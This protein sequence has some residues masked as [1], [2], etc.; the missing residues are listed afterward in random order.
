MLHGS[1]EDKYPALTIANPDR[2]HLFYCIL[3]SAQDPVRFCH[4]ETD[5][6]VG[7]SLGVGNRINTEFVCISRGPDV[8]YVSIVEIDASTVDPV[9]FVN[10]AKSL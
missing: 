6:L 9:Q 10:F 1:L 8:S 4:S 5:N 3:H 2:T 7:S